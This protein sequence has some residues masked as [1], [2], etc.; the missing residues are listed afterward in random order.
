M[1][2]KRF[3]GMVAGIMLSSAAVLFATGASQGPSVTVYPSTPAPGQQ[4]WVYALKCMDGTTTTQ[5]N[6]FAKSEGFVDEVK[7]SS[8]PNT[9]T[10]RG[11]ATIKRTAR[12]PYRV[13]V[14]GCETGTA[15]GNYRVGGGRHPI[16]GP[17]TGGG[18]L[19]LA[20]DSGRAPWLAGAVGVLLAAAGTGLAVALR[21]RRTERDGADL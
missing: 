14:T 12:G 4:A 1:G 8:Y 16:T 6:V 10:W 2:R 17:D 3:T 11:A 7:L 21:R 19:A 13:V 20:Q 15:V 5:G 18:G 9:T